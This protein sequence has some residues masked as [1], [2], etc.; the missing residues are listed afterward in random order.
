MHQVRKSN[1][2]EKGVE[3]TQSMRGEKECKSFHVAKQVCA[4]EA[5]ESLSLQHVDK[6][7]KALG[8]KYL[9]LCF[10]LSPHS[11]GAAVDS[12]RFPPPRTGRLTFLG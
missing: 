3:I 4:R 10:F 8:F 6:D 12:Q 11:F 7:H 1:L 5:W 9:P 2:S